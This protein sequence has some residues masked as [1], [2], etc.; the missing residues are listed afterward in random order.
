VE[1]EGY[2]GSVEGNIY[3]DEQLAL[4]L[5]IQ[6]IKKKN[7]L[8]TLKSSSRNEFYCKMLSETREALKSVVKD[9]WGEEGEKEL[10]ERAIPTLR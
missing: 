2:T 8:E 6:L 7:R 5:V 1:N 9:I 4:S 3:I 10:P